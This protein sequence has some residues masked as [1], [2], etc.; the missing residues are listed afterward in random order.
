MRTDLLRYLFAACFGQVNGRTPKMKA[1]PTSLLPQ[2]AN[3]DKAVT[4]AVFD[5]RFRVQIASQPSTTIVSHIKKDG[6]YYIHPDP[7][8]CRSLTVREA[9]RL[10]TFPDNYFFEGSRTAQYEQVGNAVPPLLAKQIA[11]V[12]Y[13]FI[14]DHGALETVSRQRRSRNMSKIRS[15]NTAPEKQVRS[16]LH[17]RGY[18]FRLHV[19]DM[20]GKP[21]IVLPKYRLV[22][23]VH[24]CFWHRHPSCKFAYSPSNRKEWWQA[25]FKRTV[26]RHR[27]VVTQLTELGWNVT[28]IWECETACPETL[29]YRL[30]SVLDGICIR[31]DG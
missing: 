19:K 26:A 25:K 23:F 21:D 12:V 13:N 17:R 24:G 31:H 14:A 7:T 16:L 15:K 8:Q 18:R 11:K 20:P 30:G 2:H 3:V 5:D 10:Q 29:S 28:V 22:I 1:F 4:G 9:A 27:E 6:H